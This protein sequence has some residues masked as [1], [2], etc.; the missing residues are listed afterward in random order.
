MDGAVV[1]GGDETASSM[2][3][4]LEASLVDLEASLSSEHCLGGGS[5]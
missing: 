3:A 2:V 5:G 4:D 1:V